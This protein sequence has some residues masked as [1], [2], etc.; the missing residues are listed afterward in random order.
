MNLDRIQ[1]QARARGHWQGI[2]L[3]I[4]LARTYWLPL[5]L[6]WL[7]PAG[8]F[9]ALLNCIFPSQPVYCAIGCWWLKAIL[10][11]DFHFTT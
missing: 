4:A 7:I 11:I 8:L 6:S 5:L 3:G 10:G 9:F 2:D 1:I